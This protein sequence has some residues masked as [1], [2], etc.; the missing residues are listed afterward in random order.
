M[1]EGDLGAGE[2]LMLGGGEGLMLGEES[3]RLTQKMTV[4]DFEGQH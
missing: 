2:G 4:K 3:M 1:Q